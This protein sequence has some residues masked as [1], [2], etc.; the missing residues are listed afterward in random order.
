MG[1]NTVS[2]SWSLVKFSLDLNSWLW[3]SLTPGDLGKSP[4]LLLLEHMTRLC[5]HTLAGEDW[6]VNF[7]FASVYLVSNLVLLGSLLLGLGIWGFVFLF[8][9]RACAALYK[10]QKRHFINMHNSRC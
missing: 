8:L 5:N 9:L 4:S 1:P 7:L 10:P 3:N 2:V 6:G